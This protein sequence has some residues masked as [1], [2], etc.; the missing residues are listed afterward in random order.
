ME[1]VPFDTFMTDPGL[2]SL[3]TI[4]GIDQV[5]ILDSDD[6]SAGGHP[7]AQWLRGEMQRTG[8]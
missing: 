4:R 2:L 7:V 6:V 5:E 1:E 3:C 8:L